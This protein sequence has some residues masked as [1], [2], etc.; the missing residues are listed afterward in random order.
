M[1]W[2]ILILLA[3]LLALVV[4][5]GDATASYAMLELILF[6]LYSP[7][8]SRVTYCIREGRCWYK[9]IFSAPAPLSLTPNTQPVQNSDHFINF[10]PS[11][12]CPHLIYNAGTPAQK[13]LWLDGLWAGERLKKWRV[14]DKG[15][16]W[17]LGHFVFWV[18]EIC[19]Y[20]W[21]ETD[22]WIK[23]VSDCVF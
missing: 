11:S 23:R 7:P 14:P 2:I 12:S 19:I 8:P 16:K 10:S 21:G 13:V 15:K 3:N 18:G 9:F 1:T 5:I 6:E 20:I 4:C 22:R 17:G